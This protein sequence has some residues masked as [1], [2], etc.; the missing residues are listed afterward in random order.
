MHVCEY[1]LKTFHGKISKKPNYNPFTS[2]IR[3]SYRG[4]RPRIVLAVIGGA[5]SNSSIM[6]SVSSSPVSDDDDFDYYIDWWKKWNPYLYTENKQNNEL[7]K[8][9]RH[10]EC[11]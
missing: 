4:K 8:N 7:Q 6:S 2:K 11:V 3:N 10:T 9:N 5:I 1:L